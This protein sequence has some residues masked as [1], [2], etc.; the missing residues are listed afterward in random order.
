MAET[1][2]AWQSL[3]RDRELNDRSSIRSTIVHVMELS[4]MYRGVKKLNLMFV[5][6]IHKVSST[7]SRISPRRNIV[8]IPV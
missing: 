1:T 3:P 2:W 7:P 6:L 8:S 4:P 5:G